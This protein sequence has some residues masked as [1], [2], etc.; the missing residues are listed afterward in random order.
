MFTL[1]YTEP[2]GW[3]TLSARVWDVDLSLRT[4][5]DGTTEPKAFF[6]LETGRANAY[7]EHVIP[8]EPVGPV[9]QVIRRLVRSE[10]RRLSPSETPDV[11]ETVLE[12]LTCAF[13]DFVRSA[14]V[15]LDL[16]RYAGTR[17]RALAEREAREAALAEPNRTAPF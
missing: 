14:N 4:T 13:A 1:N 2:D 17:A 7:T 16:D 10:I 6:R 8:V 3:P 5:E 11:P 15:S 12:L 9:T